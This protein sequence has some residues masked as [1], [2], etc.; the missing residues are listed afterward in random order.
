MTEKV[1]ILLNDLRKFNEIFRKD[2]TYYNFKSLKKPGFHPLL[3]NHREWGERQVLGLN[4]LKRK[5]VSGKYGPEI[6]P[7]LDTFHAVL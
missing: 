3:K 7:Y 1:F 6:T 5:R 2:G 4:E